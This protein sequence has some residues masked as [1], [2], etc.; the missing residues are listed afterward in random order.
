M[1]SVVIW[2]A[3]I[4]KALRYWATEREVLGG[5]IV[6]VSEISGIAWSKTGSRTACCYLGAIWAI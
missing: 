3:D 1:S 5:R 4:V 6:S 2:T